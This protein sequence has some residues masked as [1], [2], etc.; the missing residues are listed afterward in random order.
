MA[1]FLELYRRFGVHFDAVRAPVSGFVQQGPWA[2][3]AVQ[4][5]II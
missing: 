5:K 1:W 3:T 2:E 4:D